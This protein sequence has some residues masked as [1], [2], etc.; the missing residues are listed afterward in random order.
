LMSKM[1]GQSKIPSI[2]E[3]RKICQSAPD[4]WYS[5]TLVRPVSIYITK[6]LLYTP[7]SANQVTILGLLFGIAAGTLFIFGNYWYSIIGALLLHLTIVL[8][9]VDGEVA[10]YRGTSSLRGGYLDDANHFIT[11]PYIFVGIAFGVYAN[12]HNIEAL[13]FGFSA[14]LSYAIIRGL[15]RG[16]LFY[17]SEAGKPTHT[18]MAE[19]LATRTSKRGGPVANLLRKMRGKILMPSNIDVAMNVILIGAILNWLPVIIVIYGIILPCELLL[20]LWL[21]FR[22][23]F[24]E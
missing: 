23:G 8:D 16:K 19:T 24:P 5:R 20:Q 14:S 9:D 11:N 1:Q 12:F 17:L 4:T 22:F 18:S 21:D 3:L 6:V 10:H 7:I 15:N 2:K 13:I